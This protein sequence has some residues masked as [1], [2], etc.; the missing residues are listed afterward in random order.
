[1]NAVTY[2]LGR[3]SISHAALTAI[4]IEVVLFGILVYALP[5]KT[6]VVPAAHHSKIMLSFPVV[7]KKPPPPK[8][9]VKKPV[10]KPH[11]HPKPKPAHH[12]VHHRHIPKPPPPKPVA[13]P[14]P[15]LPKAVTVPQPPPKPSLSPDV[16]TRFEQQV[17]A[18]IQSALMY[19]YAAKM[20]HLS[21]RVRVSFTYRAGVVTDI[22]ILQGSPY[23]MFNSAAN[24]AV[25]SAE[26]PSPPANLGNRVLQFV[27]WVRF[28]Q[29]GQGS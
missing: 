7:A 19:P 13:K 24:Q 29:V 28:D 20:A 17:H 10:V 5:H 25:R 16:M 9:K 1:M 26:F 4:V 18:A 21:G 12:V 15:V 27:L 11:P 14:T 8:P 2:P 23:A 6:V 22:R 3:F